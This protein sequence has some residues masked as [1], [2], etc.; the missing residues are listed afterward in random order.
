[1][2]EPLISVGTDGRAYV[3]L[4]EH[5]RVREKMLDFQSALVD[6]VRRLDQLADKRENKQPQPWT[7]P[8]A[9][10]PLDDL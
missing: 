7:E 5:E 9:P 4:E 8:T 6:I 1:M 2:T 10:A 3:L